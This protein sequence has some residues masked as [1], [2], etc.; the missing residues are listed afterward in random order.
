MLKTGFIRHS[1]GI[2]F[3]ELLFKYILC[4]R[5]LIVFVFQFCLVRLL[6]EQTLSGSLVNCSRTQLL[7]VISTQ[8]TKI[9]E[10]PKF[11]SSHMNRTESHW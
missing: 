1:H 3:N 9:K 11:A 2:F 4:V 7:K 8:G 10:I 5:S 6:G